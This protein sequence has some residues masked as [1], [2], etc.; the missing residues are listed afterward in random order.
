MREKMC[1]PNRA[2]R[3]LSFRTEAHVHELHACGLQMVLVQA[4]SNGL[5]FINC[6]DD[7][8]YFLTS[9]KDQLIR[10]WDMRWLRPEAATEP[11]PPTTFTAAAPRWL[12]SYQGHNVFSTLIRAR[13]SPAHTTGQRYIV[14]G[15]EDGFVYIYDVLT[16]QVVNVIGGHD[17]VVRDVAW[18]PYAPLILS[19][20]WDGSIGCIEPVSDGRPNIPPVQP[21]SRQSARN[22]FRGAG[23]RMNDFIAA[24]IGG[25]DD[26]D[27]DDE[28]DGG[29]AGD[30]DADRGDDDDEA[31]EDDDDDDPVGP[32]NDNDSWEDTDDASATGSASGSGL[33]L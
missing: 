19:A 29:I 17:D 7:G 20:S 22:M 26:N 32:S 23:V 30:A 5:N 33:D 27:N 3:P 9:S 4:H 15:S 11:R 18:H 25:D 8:R 1:N 28:A 21:R 6:H 24:M 31:E 13:F 16:G 10:L 12:M 14:S 2:P